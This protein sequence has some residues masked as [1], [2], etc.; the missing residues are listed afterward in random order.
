MAIPPG[1]RLGPH[2]VLAAIGAGGMGEVYRARDTRLDRI[3]AIKILPDHLAHRTDLR[4]RFERE[5]RAIASLNHPHICIIYDV[6]HQDGTDYLVMEYLEG[7]T[8]AHRLLKGSLPVEQVLQYS[9]QI[10]DALDKAHRKGITHRDLKPSNIMLT[11]SG[12]KLLDFGLAKLRERGALSDDALSALQTLSDSITGEGNIIGTLQYMAPEQLEGIDVD[13]R[14]DIFAFGAV[15]YEMATGRKAFE[16]KSRASLIAKILQTDSPPMSSLQPVTPPGL[17][18]IVK[19]CLAKDPDERWQNAGDLARELKW[20]ADVATQTAGSVS[21]SVVTNDD[22]FGNRK[23]TYLGWAAAAVLLVA[24]GATF[25]RQSTGEAPAASSVT[26]TSV[27]LPIGQ[28]LT[29]EDGDYP[30]AVSPDGTR[31]AYVAEADAGTQLYVCSRIQRFRTEGNCGYLR[32]QTSVFFTGWPLGR[33][34]WGRH[35]TE[36]LRCR[37]GATSNLQHFGLEPRRQLGLR[38]H[39]GVR[40]ARYR[41]I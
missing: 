34:L 33:I 30:M 31:M 12:A 9:I 41:S 18:R 21:V 1:T 11:K 28:R 27:V 32:S 24:F 20:I 13:A 17:E 10:A 16:S 26:R 39:R 2:E 7:Q 40:L 15:L 23:S 14:T 6:G 5:A 25:F 8:L 36:G 35:P 19:L 22:I 4:E 3:V 38:Q 37:W 29:S